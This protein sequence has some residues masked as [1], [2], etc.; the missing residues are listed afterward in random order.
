[1]KRSQTFFLHLLL[2]N[3]AG[4]VTTAAL[5]KLSSNG[6]GAEEFPKSGSYVMSGH[7][8]LTFSEI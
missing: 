4:H 3:L 1:M 6:K 8:F 2:Q 7:I 5:S